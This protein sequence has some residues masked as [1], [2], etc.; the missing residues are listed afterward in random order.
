ML[1]KDQGVA[2]LVPV[3]LVNDQKIGVLFLTMLEIRGCV[4]GHVG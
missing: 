1:S 4:P 3:R 2:G